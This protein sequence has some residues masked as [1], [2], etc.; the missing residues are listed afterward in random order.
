V[1]YK[2]IL[3]EIDSGVITWR[4]L[5]PIYPEKHVFISTRSG[6]AKLIQQIRD[7]ADTLITVDKE[8]TDIALEFFRKEG[9]A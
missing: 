7:F 1:Q 4:A 6:L 8:F 3:R 9:Y 2:P 5:S